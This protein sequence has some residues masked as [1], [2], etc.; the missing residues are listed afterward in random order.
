MGAGVDSRGAMELRTTLSDLVGMVRA[1]AAKR[2]KPP[3]RCH[4]PL[5]LFAALPA[6]TF[7]PDYGMQSQPLPPTLL[8]DKQSV[9]EISDHISSVVEEARVA[10]GLAPT[11]SPSGKGA[12]AGGGLAGTSHLIKTLRGSNIRPLFLAAP[13]V[14]NAQSA[15]FGFMAY[16]GWSDRTLFLPTVAALRDAAMRSL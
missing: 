3:W 5:G 7:D 1:A 13:G 12:A 8:Y 11:A 14:A 15:Y 9:D 6:R 2:P 4:R 10:A 16:L